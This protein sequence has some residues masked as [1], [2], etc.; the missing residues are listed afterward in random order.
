MASTHELY[1]VAR[2]G[3]LLTPSDLGH[4]AKAVLQAERARRALGLTGTPERGSC[5]PDALERG[6]SSR[7]GAVSSCREDVWGIEASGV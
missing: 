7:Q 1:L 3:A 5:I 2:A 4:A 6:P